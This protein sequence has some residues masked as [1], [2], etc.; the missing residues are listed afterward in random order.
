M[1]EQGAWTKFQ[2]LVSALV[3]IA[4]VLV[5]YIGVA[6]NTKLWPF[7]DVSAAKRPAAVATPPGKTTTPSSPT[8]TT[9]SSP[10]PTTPSSPTLTSSPSSI[11]SLGSV[12]AT[13]LSVTWAQT[14]SPYY[15]YAYT[16]KIRFTSLADQTCVIDWKTVYSSGAPAGTS[17]KLTTG[18][19]P[20][21]DTT[22]TDTI[23]VTTPSG[24]FRGMQWSTDFTVYAP[25]GVEMA[26]Y[27]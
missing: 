25:N 5:T 2:V 26:S 14:T 23:D 8:P 18:T 7:E 27:G 11:P 16:I 21:P 3:A 9:P 24:A 6:A 19:L 20:Y 17:G 10:T 15:Y 13:I 4:G 12:S 22:W 1:A